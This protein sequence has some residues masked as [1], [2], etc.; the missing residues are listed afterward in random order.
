MP[1]GRVEVIACG[2]DKALAVLQAWLREGPP[3]AQVSD[4]QRED[5]EDELV[6]NSFEII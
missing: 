1:D 3:Q 4:V 5:C 6:F 2:S